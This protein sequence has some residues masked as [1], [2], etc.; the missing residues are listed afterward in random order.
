MGLKSQVCVG[1]R[2]VCRAAPGAEGAPR[3]TGGR[4]AHVVG[5]G[6]ASTDH[7]DLAGLLGWGTRGIQVATSSI[8]CSTEE[9]C[10]SRP[11]SAMEE[12][13]RA[14]PSAT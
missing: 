12:G 9:P 8:S 5:M 6:A 13:H 7:Q 11:P 14:R 1:T 3:A 2:L 4:R 10:E